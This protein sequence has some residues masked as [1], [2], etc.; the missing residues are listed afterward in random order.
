ME[1]DETNEDF[2][3][4]DL[5]TEDESEDE[6][7]EKDW[8]AEAKKYKAIATRLK[9][10][11]E[12]PAK[13]PEKEPEKLPTESKTSAPEDL[14]DRVDLRLQGYTYEE[15]EF[16]NRNRNG[17]PLKE[18]IK[19]PFVSAGIEAVRS[20]KKAEDK[21]PSP[22]NRSTKFNGKTYEEIVR[23]GSPEEKQGAF[24]QMMTK[25]RTNQSE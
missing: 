17:R 23:D 16:A 3:L 11:Q 20:Q 12:T 4:E 13:E 8:E 24:E 22:S 19:D 21:T 25:R 15:I 10:K 2:E 1:K 6:S 18:A 14:E 7:E 9:K 5:E